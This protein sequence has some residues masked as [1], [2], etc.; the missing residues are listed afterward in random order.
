[1]LR[2]PISANT[3]S[4][5]CVNPSLSPPFIGSQLNSTRGSFVARVLLKTYQLEDFL[6]QIV[7]NDLHIAAFPAL[8]ERFGVAVLV[9][10]VENRNTGRALR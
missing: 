8:E 9:V 5:L 1:M 3:H 7:L 4:V 6:S 2:I 10:D